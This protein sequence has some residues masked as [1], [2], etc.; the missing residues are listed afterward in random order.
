MRLADG[1][2]LCNPDILADLADIELTQARMLLYAFEAE[3]MIQRDIDCTIEATILLTQPLETI[4]TQITES[5]ERE[6]ARSL[7]SALKAE[8]EHQVTYR[9]TEV[10]AQT[11]IDP[12]LIDPLLVKLAAQELLLYRAYSRGITFKFNQRIHTMINAIEARFSSRYKRFEER[13]NRMIDFTKLKREQNRCRSAELIN[14]LTG[15]DNTPAC[16]KCDLCSPTNAQLPWNPGVRLY[17]EHIEV[18]VRMAVLGTI[19][20]HNGVYARGTIERMLLGPEFMRINGQMKP[21]SASV[22]SSDHFEELKDRKI[23]KDHLQRTIDALVEGGYL[24]LVEKS[25]RG[26]DESNNVYQALSI[27]QRGRDALAS[28]TDLPNTKEAK[29]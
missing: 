27:T 14:Y 10:Y 20:E 12:R 15:E 7:F 19:R 8:P 3:G 17:G 21:I 22:R 13:L 29:V 28:G 23:S 24:Q 25:W 16:G 1:A 9:A 4:L 6:M 2:L 18:D 11:G 5:A 26:K